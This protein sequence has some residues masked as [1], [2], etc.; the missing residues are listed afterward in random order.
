[1]NH[2]YIETQI[3]RLE[4]DVKEK[5]HRLL[6]TNHQLSSIQAD[7]SSRSDVLDTLK[8]VITDKEKQIDKLVFH[9]SPSIHL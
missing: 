8:H 6:H 1:M 5:E 4:D 2:N 3:E 9:S 7:C